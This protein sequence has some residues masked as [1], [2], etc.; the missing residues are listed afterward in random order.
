MDRGTRPNRRSSAEVRGT[1]MRRS[2]IVLAVLLGVAMFSALTPTSRVSVKASLVD[3]NCSC[4][5]RVAYLDL[6]SNQALRKHDLLGSATHRESA[7]RQLLSCFEGRRINGRPADSLLDAASRYFF[8]GQD[9]HYGGDA[10]RSLRLLKKSIALNRKVLSMTRNQSRGA[11]DT[12][13]AAE[14]YL[15]GTWPPAKVVYFSPPD[16]SQLKVKTCPWMSAIDRG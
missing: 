6:L 13:K 14:G 1:I 12:I 16:Y 5:E 3:Q 11:R 9:A 7:G 2:L 4:V 8:A 15:R 10:S